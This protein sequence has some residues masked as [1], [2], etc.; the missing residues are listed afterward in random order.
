MQMRV[1]GGF[2]YVRPGSNQVAGQLEFPAGC[3]GWVKDAILRYSPG[4]EGRGVVL[5]V[6]P[7]SQGQFHIEALA[8]STG[9]VLRGPGGQAVRLGVVGNDYEKCLS[10][11]VFVERLNA[12]IGPEMQ[13]PRGS[14][15]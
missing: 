8:G 9:N 7:G 5:R 4:G 3:P 14:R 13:R 15:P 2:P 10:L 6:T 12:A 1:T 11:M